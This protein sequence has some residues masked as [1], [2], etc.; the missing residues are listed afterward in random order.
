MRV[1]I[2]I[3]AQVLC[4]STASLLEGKSLLDPNTLKGIY[5]GSSMMVQLS[6]VKPKLYFV[7]GAMA[8]LSTEL[9]SADSTKKGVAQ[10]LL[11][12]ARKPV[13]VVQ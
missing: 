8:S 1:K 4:P 11:Y 9:S 13:V 10:G 7:L 5:F 6:S 3:L 12:K 2:I